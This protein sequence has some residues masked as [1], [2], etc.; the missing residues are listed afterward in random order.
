MN[1]G[2][3]E[4][5]KHIVNLAKD[6]TDEETRTLHA[7]ISSLQGLLSLTV[8]TR[9]IEVEYDFPN[10]CLSQIWETLRDTINTSDIGLFYRLR[11]CL[12]SFAEDN[13]TEHL[14]YPQNW[15]TYVEDIYVYYYDYAQT[16]NDNVREKMWRRYKANS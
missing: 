1:S 15:D 7:T 12:F 6:L 4:P 16:G 8:Q 2:D 5:R 14:L 10:L 9:H 13:E 3:T 11:L